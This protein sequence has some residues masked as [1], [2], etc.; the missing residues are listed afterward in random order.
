MNQLSGEVVQVIGPVVDVSFE[1]TG[2]GLPE[3]R[4]ALYI[5]REGP[6]L[7]WWKCISILGACGA[8][9]GY[10]LHRWFASGDEGHLPGWFHPDAVGEQVRGRSA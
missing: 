5:E 9:R 7:L 1:R 10:G 8:H 3:I 6:A 2:A 4:D